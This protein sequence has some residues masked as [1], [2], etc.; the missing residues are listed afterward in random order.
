MSTYR[1]ALL[2]SANIIPSLTVVIEERLEN[3]VITLLVSV[4]ACGIQRTTTR[5][6]MDWKNWIDEKE[7]DNSRKFREEKFQAMTAWATVISSFKVG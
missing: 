7:F 1:K 6:K 3:T 4:D 2:L 5:L